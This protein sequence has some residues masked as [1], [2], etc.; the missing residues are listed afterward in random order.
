MLQQMRKAQSW[1]LKWVLG[2]VIVAFVV[3]IFYSWGV[4]SSSGPVRT[5]VATILGERVGIQEFQRAH[6]TL[7]QTYRNIFRNQPE[8]D[9][10]EQFNFREMALE[11]IAK[12]HLL[13]R[14]AQQNHLIVTDAELYNRIATIPAFQEQ[15][16]FSPARYQAVLQNQVPRIVP[17]QFEE[18]QRQDLFVEKVYSLLRAAVQVTDTEVEQ[19]YRW[20]HAQVAVRYVTLVPSLFASQVQVT[21]EDVRAYYEAHKEAYREPEQ[22]QIQYMA[23]APQRFRTAAALPEDEI[24]RYYASHQEAFRRQEEVRARH[25]LFKAAEDAPQEQEAEVRARA[26]RVLQEL[27]NGADF[28]ALAQ[29]YSE[30]TSTAEK[31]GDLGF[32]PRGQMVKP[33]EDVVFSLPVGQ[34]SDL[35]RTDF[36]YHIIRVEDRVAADLKPLAEVRQEIIDKLQEEKAREATVAFVDDLMIVLE[37]TPEQFSTLA[38]Q[39]GLA[40]TTT[41]F[42]S[43]T[44]RVAELETAPEV[45]PRAFALVNRAV[46]AVEGTD[47]TYYIFRVVDVQPSTIPEV[48]AVQERVTADLRQQ[49][50]TELAGQTA[51]EWASKVRAGTPLEDL[52]APLQ[53]QVI[54]TELFRRRDP[55]P[56]LG[57]SAAFS[58]T[59]FSLQSDEVGAAHESARH[60]VVQ[61]T[62]R[63]DADMQAYETEKA[64]YYKQVLDRKQQ[65]ILLSFQDFLQAQ[66]QKLRQSGEIVVNPQHV[67]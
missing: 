36:G 21:D 48:A 24:A 29:Q 16:H 1:M 20:E 58:Q 17:K 26:E 39:H 60:F 65:Q 59:A 62:A 53:V 64:T 47:G 5:E 61:V 30:D 42:V 27:R 28:T 31:G 12:R 15:G 55:V 56:Q 6:N 46:D 22:R 4:R 10:R 33:F 2:T 3:T 54:A 8:V 13:L 49:K 43:R 67:F 52:A 44:A 32:F 51:D 18:E 66:Y 38:D 7:Y 41:P 11:Q 40:V 14:L 63:Q 23:I 25:I 19:A 45:V 37:E 50:S 35:V 34:L 57:R 9:L